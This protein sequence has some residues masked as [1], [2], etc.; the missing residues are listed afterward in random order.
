MNQ[1]HESEEVMKMIGG[2]ISGESRVE[3]IIELEEEGPGVLVRSSYHNQE[4]DELGVGQLYAGRGTRYKVSADDEK[5]EDH[6]YF[7][8]ELL[9][10]LAP[11][12]FAAE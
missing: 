5:D 10:C 11:V 4:R 8:M 2:V 3:V 6:F 1:E 12:G 7:L 9:E